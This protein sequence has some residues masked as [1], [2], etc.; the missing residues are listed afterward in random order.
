MRLA[1]SSAKKQML[2]KSPGHLITVNADE[3]DYELNQRKSPKRG[4]RFPQVTGSRSR[5]SC[6]RA[7]HL[8]DGAAPSKGREQTAIMLK[9][10]YKF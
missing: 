8:E 5:R 4:S 3:T 6:R 10:E 7:A 2:G 1:H 9:D